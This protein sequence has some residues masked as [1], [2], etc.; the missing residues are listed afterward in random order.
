L[1][2]FESGKTTASDKR[3]CV[4]VYVHLFLCVIRVNSTCKSVNMSVVKLNFSF[5]LP[6]QCC[7]HEHIWWPAEVFSTC[8]NYVLDI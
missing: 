6:S 2:A 3:M 1:L 5:S 4:W 7:C 8:E